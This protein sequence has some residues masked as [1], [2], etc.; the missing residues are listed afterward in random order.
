[1][2]NAL[3][4]YR[5]RWRSA[6]DPGDGKISKAYSTF[7]RIKNT[8]WMYSSD[9]FRVRNIS[10]GYNLGNLIST[11]YVQGA[12]VYLTLENFFGKDYYL[13][14]FNPDA[15]NTDL[16]GNTSFPEPGDYGGMPIPRSLVFGVNFTF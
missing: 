3:G 10:L 2:D 7:G 16:S 9:Y 11:K 6:A 5:H 13:G 1:V 15:N 12:R 14:G 8:D 4:T